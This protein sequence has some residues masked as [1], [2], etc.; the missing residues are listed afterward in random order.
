MKS[1]LNI[2]HK[3]T[4]EE[5]LGQKSQTSEDTMIYEGIREIYLNRRSI[6]SSELI[7]Q[8]KDILKPEHLT[9]TG[10]ILFKSGIS[11]ETFHL[12]I[13]PQFFEGERGYHYDI[14][15]KH[16]DEFTLIGSLTAQRSLTIL[17]KCLEMTDEKRGIY[18]KNYQVIARVLELCKGSSE[19]SLD[20]ITPKLIEDQG[21]FLSNP[22]TLQEIIEME[23]E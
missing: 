6:S 9:T 15:L 4:H 1:W 8:L 18:R 3:N 17:F 21:I 2:F 5:Q 7:I 13:L 19:I 23:E 16:K 22:E 12:G 14:H 11:G 10:G 20:W